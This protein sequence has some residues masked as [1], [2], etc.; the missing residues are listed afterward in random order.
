MCA[1]AEFCLVPT[2]SVPWHLLS[3]CSFLRDTGAARPGTPAM[4][5]ASWTCSRNIS[6]PFSSLGKFPS[7]LTAWQQLFCSCRR[8]Q[9]PAGACSK[10]A[11][12]KTQTG[13]WEALLGLTRNM[14]DFLASEA[15]VAVPGS[16]SWR[17]LIKALLLRQMSQSSAMISFYLQCWQRVCLTN[18]NF[19]EPT[20][21]TPISSAGSLGKPPAGID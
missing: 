19:Q 12:T 5:A 20:D 21:K 8:I 2:S 14:L 16:F 18:F 13:E 17:R 1:V 4:S 9:Q 6:A 10:R 7:L 15:L 11:S 3:G